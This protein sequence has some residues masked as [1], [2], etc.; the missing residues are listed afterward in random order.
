[1][2]VE[3]RQ[4]AL[5]LDPQASLRTELI[6]QLAAAQLALEAAIA[7]LGRSGANSA[8]IGE[9]RSQLSALVSLRQQIGTLSGSAL[10]DLRSEVSAAAASATALAQQISGNTSNSTPDGPTRAAAARA[11]M[12]KV[13]REVFEDKVLD[14]YLQFA[15]KEDEEAY[16]KRERERKEAY[17]RARAMGTPDGDR[18]AAQIAQEQIQDAGAHG[19]DR[20]PNFAPMQRDIALARRD[21]EAS[22]ASGAASRDNQPPGRAREKPTTEADLSDVMAALSAAGVTTTD[23]GTSKSK[24]GL[25]ELNPAQRSQSANI[26]Q[27]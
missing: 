14:P 11:T 16:R 4:A 7:E 23:P 10:A 3:G 24:H 25:A 21:L 8:A 9:S 5:P 1:M 20:S 12:E 26:V 18:L 17:D 27:V 13:G 15:S 19:A 2:T 22:I 6:G